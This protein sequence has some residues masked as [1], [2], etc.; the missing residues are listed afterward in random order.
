MDY[1][2]RPVI[3]YSPDRLSDCFD[4]CVHNTQMMHNLEKWGPALH[5]LRGQKGYLEGML[6]KTVTTLNALRDR[7]TRNQCILS[8][9][10]TPR[11]KRKK[12]QQD[13]WRTDKTIQTCENEEKIILDCLRVCEN[14]IQ[15]LEAIIYPPESSLNSAE[16]YGS[17]SYGELDTASFDWQGWTDDLVISPFE[18]TRTG[19][20]PLDEVSPDTMAGCTQPRSAFLVAPPN[21]AYTKFMPRPEATTFKP[22]AAHMQ[23]SVTQLARELDKLTISGF[24]A[25]KR[26][27]S[28][29][30]RRFSDEAIAFRRFPSTVEPT[31]TRKGSSSSWPGQRRL[32]GNEDRGSAGKARLKRCISI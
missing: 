6:S 16:H 20:L 4:A 23:L 15:T 18:R 19:P 28:I 32:R 24:L 29:H 11:T 22:S 30:R 9:N 12:I 17:N 5:N 13:R 8:T 27:S 3:S 25:S 10:P 31:P 1:G 26:M 2:V 7:Q 14:N 21:S